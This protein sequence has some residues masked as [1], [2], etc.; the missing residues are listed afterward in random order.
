V[1]CESAVPR[2]TVWDV[3][4]CEGGEDCVSSGLCE[5][6]SCVCVV[7]FFVLIGGLYCERWGMDRG[8]CRLLNSFYSG[9]YLTLMRSGTCRAGV[10]RPNC[11]R[12]SQCLVTSTFCSALI[13]IPIRTQTTD[14]L[15]DQPTIRA[16]SAM[17][18]LLQR[19]TERNQKIWIT[20]ECRMDLRHS[21]Y[22]MCF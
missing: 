11:C 18:P 19:L 16:V 21:S 12:S 1:A 5:C 15:T 6:M 17:P 7:F 9:E 8:R 14:L 2:G 10:S 3:E 20:L 13:P 4:W 22:G